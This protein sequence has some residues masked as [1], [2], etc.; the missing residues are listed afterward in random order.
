[1]KNRFKNSLLKPVLAI[2]ISFLAM[3]IFIQPFFPAQAF[4]QSTEEENAAKKIEQKWKKIEYTGGE[5]GNPIGNI[6]AIFPVGG[7]SI[8]AYSQEFE[9]GVIVYSDDFG[10]LLVSKGIIDKW[11]SLETQETGDGSNLFNYIGVP[12]D[13]YTSKGNYEEGRFERGCILIEQGFSEHVVYGEIYGKF[14]YVRENIGLPVS[15]QEDVTLSIWMDDHYDFIDDP[16]QGRYQKF[17]NGAIYWKPDLKEA[18]A[19][20]GPISDRYK[21]FRSTSNLLGYPVSDTAPVLNYDGVQIGTTVR[22]E[23]GAIYDS[24]SGTWTVFDD[25]LAGYEKEGGPNGWLG[26]P[27]SYPKVNA[28]GD[29]Y[30]DF[31]NGVLVNYE[32]ASVMPFGALEFYLERIQGYGDDQNGLGGSVDIYAYLDMALRYFMWVNRTSACLQ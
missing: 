7:N 21:E 14:L 27:V 25:L 11:L 5:I 32:E 16:E 24:G 17:T 15:E 13:D 19:V 3:E 31:E 8:I 12:I 20:W 30:Q 26:F 23:G 2:A 4:A 29:W 22:F 10:A 1:M 9:E 18:Y 28:A 6:T